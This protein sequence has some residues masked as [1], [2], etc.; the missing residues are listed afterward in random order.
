M[1][2]CNVKRVHLCYAML[3]EFKILP[4]VRPFIKSES[5]PVVGFCPHVTSTEVFGINLKHSLSKKIGPSRRCLA[6]RTRQSD[7]I[8]LSL[9]LSHRSLQF[10]ILAKPLVFGRP[11]LGRYIRLNR[12]RPIPRP[13]RK[14]S[15]R[16]WDLSYSDQL[17]PHRDNQFS[18]FSTEVLVRKNRDTIAVV[19][20][21]PP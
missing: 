15:L 1:W 18:A 8:A 11:N 17:S 5:W 10:Y 14:K 6:Q 19:L 7:Y 21:V 2:S 12:T 13:K 16:I 4:S 20:P 3:F 9:S